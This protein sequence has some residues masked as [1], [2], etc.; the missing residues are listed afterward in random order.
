[1]PTEKW[2]LYEAK[3]TK[4]ATDKWDRFASTA[5]APPPQGVPVGSISAVKPPSGTGGKVEQWAQQL[6]NDLKHGTDIT[7][8]GSFLKKMGAQPLHAG[9]P[10]GVGDLLSSPYLGPMRMVK[11]GA[12]GAQGKLWKGTK[13]VVG[14]GMEAATIPAMMMM[15]ANPMGGPIMAGKILPSTEKAGKLLEAVEQVAGKVSVELESPTKAAMEIVQNAKSGGSRPKVIADFVRRISD[16]KQPPL[17]Y[18]EA[19]KFYENAISKFAPDIQGNV[20]KG[21]PRY[22]LGKFAKSLDQA[23]QGAAKQA[24]VEDQYVNAMKAYHKAAQFQSA[25][26]KV[27][28]KVKQGIGLAAGGAATAMGAKEGYNWIKK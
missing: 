16:Q 13:D 4:E 7:G 18:A 22:M 26:S 27:G 24:G 10:A 25:A 21:K 6:I 8:A 3:P 20:L 5:V 19:R 15:M 1:M 23:I 2:D 12:E 14:G 9:Q 28:K 17:T 11:G